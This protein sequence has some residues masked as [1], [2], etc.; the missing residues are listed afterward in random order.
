MHI[1]VYLKWYYHA[2][3]AW[4]DNTN[5]IFD[6]NISV[7]KIPGF[8]I[9]RQKL[10]LLLT[11]AEFHVFSANSRMNSRSKQRGFHTTTGFSCWA[12]D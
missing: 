4:S 10:I 11:F 12:Q 2:T 3:C 7:K 6:E 5:P 9:L 8:A 1:S